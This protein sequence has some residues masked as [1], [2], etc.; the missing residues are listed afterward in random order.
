MFGPSNIPG[1]AP[2]YWTINAGIVPVVMGYWISFVKALDPSVWRA[3]GAPQWE[4][5]DGNG[6]GGRRLKIELDNTT[7]ETV[8]DG[9]VERCAFWE[10]MGSRMRQ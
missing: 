10:A 2:S 6:Y 1:A 5:W 9:E 3:D 8:S 4:A 7:M